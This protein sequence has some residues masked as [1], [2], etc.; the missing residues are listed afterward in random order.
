MT[1]RSI[2]SDGP[3]KYWAYVRERHPELN[4][5]NTFIRRAHEIAA[6]YGVVYCK[7]D[8]WFGPRD[9][10][11]IQGSIPEVGVAR[12]LRAIVEQKGITYKYV[13]EAVLMLMPPCLDPACH[14]NCQRIA[15]GATS[16]A[17]QP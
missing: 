3:E 2:Q 1:T 11:D 17:R 12:A 16:I 4:A 6:R 7:S 15:H 13:Y 5:I 10:D 9:V 14:P 8:W